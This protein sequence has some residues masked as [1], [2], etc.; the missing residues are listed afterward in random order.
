MRPLPI[1]SK[2]RESSVHCRPSDGILVLRMASLFSLTRQRQQTGAPFHR[3]E[4]RRMGLGKWQAP[5]RNRSLIPAGP[6]RSS[7]VRL[8]ANISSGQL[9]IGNATG[10]LVSPGAAASSGFPACR[11]RRMM[12][13]LGQKFCGKAWRP[14]SISANRLGSP[15]AKGAS[16]QPPRS[17]G[18]Q[19]LRCHRRPRLSNH[20]C[21]GPFFHGSR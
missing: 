9:A 2:Q 17:E 4:T 3:R 12:K 11:R 15:A 14:Q 18:G 8:P 10:F 5:R 16:H 21:D 13:A 1:W 6:K 20:Q 19:A 7:P